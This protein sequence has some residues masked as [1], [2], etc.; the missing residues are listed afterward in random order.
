[1]QRE[2]QEVG[3]RVA[4]E[5]FPDR[6]NSANGDLV[7]RGIPGAVVKDP[8]KVAERAL[9][10]AE[11]QKMI[12]DDGTIID[13]KAHTLCVHG[14]TPTALDLVRSISEILT[15]NGVKIIPIDTM[16]SS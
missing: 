7:P 5:A 8:E 1:M 14:D 9:R 3:L 12:A 15:K 2:A 13:L 10:V 11:E 6:A 16:F 4:F